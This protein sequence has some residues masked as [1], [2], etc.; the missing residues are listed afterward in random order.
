MVV[1][2][3][4]RESSMARSISSMTCSVPPRRMRVTAW[5][6]STS[7]TKMR[8]SPAISFWATLPATPRSS[9]VRSSTL[10]TG[11]ALVAGF[12]ATDR[13]D[14]LLCEVVLGHVVDAAVD[15]DD[16]S[17]GVGD[18]LGHLAQLGLFLFEELLE[19]VG[20]GDVDLGVDLGLFD[21]EVA[22]DDRDVGVLGEV[23]HV[24]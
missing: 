12:D 7:S 19:L 8:W 3:T 14:V 6:S 1:R 23:G 18:L 15:E 17:T 9:A 10:E 21:F 2:T 24:L 20:V 22:V 13:D 11:L 4:P 5:A 16:V